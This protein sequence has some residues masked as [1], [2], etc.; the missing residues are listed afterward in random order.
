[1]LQ[2]LGL[3]LSVEDTTVVSGQGPRLVV[4]S[5]EGLGQQLLHV[6]GTLTAISR[7]E[8]T[9]IKP[10]SPTKSTF[11]RQRWKQTEYTHSSEVL[12]GAVLWFSDLPLRRTWTYCMVLYYLPPGGCRPVTLQ[13]NN[14]KTACLL[15]VSISTEYKERRPQRWSRSVVQT[16]QTFK[17]IH[18]FT[19]FV[20]PGHA[21]TKKKNK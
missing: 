3:C 12:I 17:N 10:L 19:S 6:E 8:A 7:T 16:S 2:L 13:H 18:H 11:T 15:S 21:H 20:S 1:M 9:S 4:C 5:R 14:N